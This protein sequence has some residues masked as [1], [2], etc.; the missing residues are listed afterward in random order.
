MEQW[1]T[2][3]ISKQK[4]RRGGCLGKIIGGALY[5]GVLGGLCH[6]WINFIESKHIPPGEEEVIEAVVVHDWFHKDLEGKYSLFN[7]IIDEGFGQLDLK[8]PESFPPYMDNYI[9]T[10]LDDCTPYVIEFPDLSFFGEDS[11]Y[12]SL[13][14]E[15]EL[16]D[17][18]RLT[19]V[20]D[21]N[22]YG[23]YFGTSI[24]L[25]GKS[26]I[27]ERCQFF[28]SPDSQIGSVKHLRSSE[29]WYLLQDAYLVDTMGAY[30]PALEDQV[31]LAKNLYERLFT[32]ENTYCAAEPTDLFLLDHAELV[33]ISLLLDY[34]EEPENRATLAAMIEE[35]FEDRLGE[36]GGRVLWDINGIE[37]KLIP[38]PV[39]DYL[40]P[41]DERINHTYYMNHMDYRNMDCL[42][43]FH[44]H[45]A[46]DD[47]NQPCP[48]DIDVEVAIGS[49][50][51]GIM[52][53]R[54]QDSTFNVTFYSHSGTV[55]DLGPY[56]S[57][58]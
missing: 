56:D 6:G 51:D 52:I 26:E 19:M 4:K 33:R 55:I 13:A 22:N 54:Q 14:D 48:S 57:G 7:P 23:R 40:E 44:F 35:D 32:V 42:A 27:P 34:L 37:F 15:I 46:Y 5:L 29:E 16:G 58:D 43:M 20:E 9:V 30:D 41:D 47:F 18:V 25:L 28:P 17:K 38:N 11:K 1:R 2:R 39:L 45:A 8:A 24:E 31:E 12:E 21:P 53:S 50:I 3:V 10:V 49:N 36:H